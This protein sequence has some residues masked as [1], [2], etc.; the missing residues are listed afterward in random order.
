M[1]P[2][3]EHGS[4]LHLTW[5]LPGRPADP[6][7]PVVSYLGNGRQA[8]RAL[9]EH[10]EWSKVWVPSYFCHDVT[11]SLRALCDIALYEAAPWDDAITL[12]VHPSEAVL[13]ME[14][15]G[16]RSQVVVEGGA[17]VMDR[18]HDPFAEH[19]YQR[20]PDYCVASLRKTFPIPDG[21][22]VWSPSGCGIPAEPPLTAV[23]AGGVL[24]M[25]TGQALKASYLAGAEVTKADYLPVLIDAESQVGAASTD[26]SG[27]SMWSRWIVDHGDRLER[28]RARSAN[29]DTFRNAWSSIDAAGWELL[30]TPAYVCLLAPE[31][32]TRDAIRARLIDR[33]VYPAVLWRLDG[34]EAPERHRRWAGRMMVLAVDFRYQPADMERVA[35]IFE[36][37][38]KA[39]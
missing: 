26:P 38:V 1:T 7:A 24:S 37:A 36:G 18:S 19:E 13:A 23:H 15:F 4:T 34:E 39:G 35:A 29:L 6:L 30:D 3:F 33:D 20:V 11:R 22:A 12:K 25:L 16:M 8:I 32:S 10:Q 9:I 21:G 27:M 5:P 2:R 31:P 28:D 14:Y 17:I